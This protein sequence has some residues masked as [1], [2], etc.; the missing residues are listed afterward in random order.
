[1][2]TR[3]SKGYVQKFH[4]DHFPRGTRV[5]IQVGFEAPFEANVMAVS[6]NGPNSWLIHTDANYPAAHSVSGF[7]TVNINHVKRILS[8]GAGSVVYKHQRLLDD[9][10]KGN[11]RRHRDL[12]LFAKKPKSA[13][14]GTS[15]NS[16]IS[17]VLRNHPAFRLGREAEYWIDID[18][19]LK[20]FAAQMPG[21]RSKGQHW[22]VIYD[23]KRLVRLL[24]QL[25][26]TH[27][28]SRRK[29]QREEEEWIA[30][31]LEADFDASYADCGTHEEVADAL[32]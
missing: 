27:K 23:K 24:K 29:M 32:C 21:K 7:V 3:A 19:L 14:V 16:I 6:S 10:H 30:K 9:E 17:E 20:S 18:R 15:L 1:M 28:V 22:L 25:I 4:V 12:C 11:E 13:Y 8:R 2:T 26:A 31:Q 5:E